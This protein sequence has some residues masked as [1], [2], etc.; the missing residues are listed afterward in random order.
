MAGLKVSVSGQTV[1]WTRDALEM[2]EIRVDVPSGA[3]SVDVDMDF[4]DPV[5]TGHFS[6]GGSMTPRLALVSWNAVLL[7]P[8]AKSSEDVQYEP[9]LRIPSGWKYATS[10]TTVS[11]N[12]N[13]IHFEPVMN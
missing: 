13:E 3:R 2:Y 4:L 12:G 1:P 11:S 5:G 6:A 10:L 7:Y 8:T 9:V